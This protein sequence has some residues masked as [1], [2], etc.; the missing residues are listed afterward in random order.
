[1]PTFS[2]KGA[3]LMNDFTLNVKQTSDLTPKELVKVM[4]ERT[5]V[6]VVEQNC[7]YQEVDEKDEDALH[8]FFTNSNEILAYTRIVLNDDEV[9][10]SFGRVLVPKNMRGKGFGRKIVTAT[11]DIISQKYPGQDIKIQAQTYLEK[12]YGSFGFLAVSQQYLEDG[13]P[14]I[15]MLLSSGPHT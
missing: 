6:F 3:H 13:I 8:I 2:K 10:P 11:L 14:H 15:D 1:M 5:K 9:H 4:Q 12:F 7:P